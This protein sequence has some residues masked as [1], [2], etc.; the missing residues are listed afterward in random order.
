[1]YAV[2]VAVADV[3]AWL[4][5]NNVVYADIRGPNILVK[6]KGWKDKGEK[7]ASEKEYYLIDYDDCYYSDEPITSVKGYI[8]F[9]QKMKEPNS[10]ELLASNIILAHAN[11]GSVFQAALEDAFGKRYG[12]IGH[13]RLRDGDTTE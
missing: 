9:L 5:G 6:E 13:K 11:A 4:A 7:H 12:L 10:S 8:A 3:V 2:A 1:M